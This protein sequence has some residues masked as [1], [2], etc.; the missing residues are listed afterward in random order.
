MGPAIALGIF[1]ILANVAANAVGYRRYR[2]ADPESLSIKPTELW[3]ALKGNPLHL[4]RN[5][6][7]LVNIVST[8]FVVPPVMMLS[9]C[10]LAASAG[11]PD[12]ACATNGAM[13][14]NSTTINGTTGSNP[15]GGVAFSAAML[16]I[17]QFLIIATAVWSLQV[18][19]EA[20]EL[21]PSV[22]NEHQHLLC[23]SVPSA[24]LLH[25]WKFNRYARIGAFVT[26]C[27]TLFLGVPARI[28]LMSTPTRGMDGTN[29]GALV[30]TLLFSMWQLASYMCLCFRVTWLDKGSQYDDYAPFVC[31]M[32][33]GTGSLTV[34][35]TTEECSQCH[36]TK[37]E[38]RK[39][40][41]Y[42]AIEIVEQA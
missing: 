16:I 33:N 38:F 30:C 5:I 42:Q 8:F 11:G 22:V 34:N 7:H 40:G 1:L 13:W 18:L 28:V 15:S 14:S 4:L 26:G 25:Q 39:Q 6:W 19:S 21:Q 36:G 20:K 27:W 17:E 37:L 9:M 32:C 41:A 2:V 35:A 12:D 3:E 31:S 23:T 29:H 24:A 10:A